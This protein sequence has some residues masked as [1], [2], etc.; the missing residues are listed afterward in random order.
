MDRQATVEGVEVVAVPGDFE[1][2]A[3]AWLLKQ[4]QHRKLNWLLAMSDDGVNWGYV[5]G[6]ALRVSHDDFP[7]VS[8]P[9]RG[10]TLQQARLFG[11]EGELYIWRTGREWA[12]RYLADAGGADTIEEV[13]LL[14]GTALEEIG[15]H[16]FTLLAEQDGLRH[17]PPPL[18]GPAFTPPQQRLALRVRHTIGYDEDGQARIVA[19]R[20]CGFAVRGRELVPAGGKPMKE[21]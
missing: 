1:G 8:P 11:E 6:E 20:L 13:Y 12:A 9:L 14:W 15:K 16:G 4:A 21:A 19:G 18:P 7:A 2:D 3:R 10:E 5:D 17:A